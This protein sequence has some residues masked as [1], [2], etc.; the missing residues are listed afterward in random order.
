MGGYTLRPGDPGTHSRWFRDIFPYVKNL[1]V[2]VCPNKNEGRVSAAEPGFRPRPDANG[3]PI[4]TDIAGGY[5]CNINV[6]NYNFQ[7]GPSYMPSKYLNEIGN[8]SGTFV[9]CDAAQL[10]MAK[11]LASPDNANAENWP[12]YQASGTYWQAWPPSDFTSSATKRYRNTT[13]GN[14]FRRPVARHGKGLTVIYAD[15][16]AKWSSIAAFLGPM[17]DG[18]PYGDPNNSWDDK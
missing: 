8:P 13:D 15:G 4:G 6:M 2:F 16:H 3:V 12:K 5:G 9:F 7:S 11:L 17:P 10:D 18:Y 14:Y 1:D